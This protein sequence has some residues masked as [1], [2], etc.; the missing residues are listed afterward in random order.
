MHTFEGDGGT[1]IHFNGGGDGTAVVHSPL[2][3]DEGVE[4][5]CQD[6]VD[7]VAEL[8]RRERISRLEGMT[9]RELFKELFG[10]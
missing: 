8:V 6:L 2:G 5:P 3:P 9:S 10:Y 1:R 4:V 7:F